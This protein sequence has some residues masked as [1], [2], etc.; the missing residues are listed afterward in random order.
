MPD[1]S[2]S[3][4]SVAAAVILALL[5]GPLGMSYVG[6]GLRAL[7]V[8]LGFGFLSFLTVIALGIQPGSHSPVPTIGGLLLFLYWLVVQPVWA[9]RRARAINIQAAGHER[10]A[11]G[12]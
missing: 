9:A 11:A 5:F 2:V 12:A 4:K 8:V 6:R 1:S 10:P 7:A 3:T